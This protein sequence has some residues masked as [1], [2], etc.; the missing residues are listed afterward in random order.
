MSVVSRNT[1]GFLIS[2]SVFVF[3]FLL[4]IIRTLFQDN[5][6]ANDLEVLGYAAGSSSALVYFLFK[7]FSTSKRITRS[8]WRVTGFLILFVALHPFSLLTLGLLIRFTVGYSFIFPVFMT[9]VW[10]SLTLY[11]S[12]FCIHY[13]MKLAGLDSEIVK[14]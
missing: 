2:L 11:C 4:P 13:G 1:L 6:Q 12:L 5:G 7:R 8:Q 10:G 3:V 14:W 9:A